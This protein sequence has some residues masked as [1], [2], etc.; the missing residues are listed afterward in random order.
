[1]LQPRGQQNGVALTRIQSLRPV[2]CDKGMLS[3]GDRMLCPDIQDGEPGNP[4]QADQLLEASDISL[5]A[6]SRCFQICSGI[7]SAL[8][9]LRAT[10]TA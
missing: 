2:P 5:S 3:E 9:R 6:G 8:I 1:M 4:G 10:A 7:S